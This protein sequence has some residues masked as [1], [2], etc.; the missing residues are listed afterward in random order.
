MAKHLILGL[1]LS[2]GMA[3]AASA[4][5]FS[6]KLLAPWDGKKVP[7]G[8]ECKIDGGNGATPPMKLSGLPK[9]TA[10]VL[11]E[12]NDLSYQPLSK[13]GGHGSIGYPVNSANPKLPAVPG[14]T[15]QLPNGIKVV[16]K[17]RSS[18]RYASKG[19]LPP[20][21][22]GRGNKYSADVKA[23]SAD[24]KVLGVV[25]VSLGKY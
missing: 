17:A 2:V 18:G 22:G 1:A 7:T 13:N 25:K 9:G 24:N 16:K 8:Q 23:I 6:V 20:C 10:W 14:M 12:Y 15:A 5:D 4:A 11:V 19:Y 3:G 21:S